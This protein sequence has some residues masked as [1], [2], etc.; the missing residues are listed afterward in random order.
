MAILVTGGSG[1]IGTN[2]IIDW[3]QFSNQSVINLDKLTYAANIN[4]LDFLKSD[5]RYHFV[6]GDICDQELVLHL[7]N[8]YQISAIVHFA[9]ESHVDKSIASP[10]NFVQTNVVGT[11]RLLE[12]AW[13]YYQNLSQILQSQFKFLHIS[14]DE[15]YGSLHAQEDSFLETSPYQ[16]N[17]PYSASKAASD[18]FVR[19][20]YQTYGLPTI[21]THC[22]N[23]YGP[24]QFP[25]K[26][27]PRLVQLAVQ[28][29][30]L[31]IY[32]DGQQ[33]RDWLYVKDHCDAIRQI[34][35]FGRCGE[36]Y[37]IGGCNEKT[38]IDVAQII[39]KILD[40]E[41]PRSDRKSYVEQLVFVEDRLGHDRR[42]AID[43]SKLR[44]ALDWHPKESFETGI[45]K[46]VKWYMQKMEI[47]A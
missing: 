17:N 9:A 14:T 4:N 20:Y 47:C 5:S 37:N 12:V 31:P 44:Q 2:F 15:V 23:N 41:K 25:E 26:F 46:T 11:F 24:Y 40:Q 13:A 39:C 33:I 10:D 28:D 34:L 29:K 18:H 21:T 35:K 32:G 30:L 8:K 36:V 7:L 42:Y 1:F 22:S 43:F 19:A 16:P 27:I 3:F 6:Q 45:F 38:N